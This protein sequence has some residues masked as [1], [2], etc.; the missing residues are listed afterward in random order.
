MTLVLGTGFPTD[1]E[2]TGLAKDSQWITRIY[3]PVALSA[4]VIVCA[5]YKVL[6]IS[7]LLL[8]NYL[9]LCSVPGIFPVDASSSLMLSVL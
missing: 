7:S 4:V 2:H 9:M 6:G 1:L 3:L 5:F 8:L